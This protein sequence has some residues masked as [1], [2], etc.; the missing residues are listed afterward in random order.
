MSRKCIVGYWWWLHST[1]NHCQ[2]Q[3]SL[4][5]H[6]LGPLIIWTYGVD[7]SDAAKA[8]WG[9][10]SGVMGSSLSHVIRAQTKYLYLRLPKKTPR[11]LCW[12]SHLFCTQYTSTHDT[13]V[14]WVHHHASMMGW[15]PM[16]VDDYVGICMMVVPLGMSQSTSTVAY[17]DC[18]K[19][20]TLIMRFIAIL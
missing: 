14:T 1:S 13:M 4:W 10:T 11:P 6:I 18:C 12:M 3:S 8:M 15:W 9:P 2:S 17:K 5:H 16:W 7:G 20:V 19:L